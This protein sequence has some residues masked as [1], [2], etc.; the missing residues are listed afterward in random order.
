MLQEGLLRIQ[1]LPLQK[2]GLRSLDSSWVKKEKWF[3][4]VEAVFQVPVLASSP[5]YPPKIS[6]LT[7]WLVVV[8]VWGWGEE[9]LE[10]NRKT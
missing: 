6:E 5:L 2:P 1:A 7:A 8:A 3:A 4:V 10:A 9:Y